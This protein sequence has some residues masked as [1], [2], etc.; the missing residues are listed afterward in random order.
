M[1]SFIKR[2]QH[3]LLLT[4]GETWQSDEQESSDETEINCYEY[5]G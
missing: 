1:V 2:N 5:S 3:N 4:L